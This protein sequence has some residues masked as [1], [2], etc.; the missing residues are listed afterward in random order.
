MDDSPVRITML[1]TTG[2]GKTTFFTAMYHELGEVGRNNF[3]I[4]ADRNPHLILSRN[5][6]ELV[7]NGKW[8][9]PNADYSEF[10]LE[11][12]HGDECIKEFD[13]VDYRGG[14]ITDL[15]DEEHYKRLSAD[16]ERSDGLLILADSW[17]IANLTAQKA[18]AQ[19]EIGTIQWFLEEFLYKEEHK[20]KKLSIGIVLTK[21][22]TVRPE[23]YQTF[24]NQCYSVFESILDLAKR[25]RSQLKVSFIP[26]SVVGYDTCEIIVSN[27]GGRIPV[28]ECKL[29]DDPKPVNIHWPILFCIAKSI[30]FRIETLEDV[31]RFKKEELH[32]LKT[33]RSGFW[34]YVS[35]VFSDRKLPFQEADELYE[36]IENKKDELYRLR[37]RVDPLVKEISDLGEASLGDFYRPHQNGGL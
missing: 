33:N 26:V 7:Q 14:A 11:L 24:R 2:V 15:E 9:K 18:N 8:P 34:D 36:D 27:N 23:Q 1:G 13:F 25:K 3:R 30:E 32:D 10:K 17:Y 20:H 35:A 5:W 4:R 29:K 28:I 6:K 16:V 19:N 22:D 31:I 21:I 12:R 37:M